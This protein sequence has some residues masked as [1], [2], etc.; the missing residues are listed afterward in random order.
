MAKITHTHNSDEHDRI[1]EVALA[2]KSQVNDLYVN[3]HNGD[4]KLNN[5][6]QLL[7]E[8]STKLVERLHMHVENTSDVDDTMKKWKRHSEIL[9]KIKLTAIGT[10]TTGTIGWLGHMLLSHLEII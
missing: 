4:V 5:R 9:N 8:E 10:A 2:I 6:I 7:I 1:M 3:H